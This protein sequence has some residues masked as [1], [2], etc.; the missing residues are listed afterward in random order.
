MLSKTFAIVVGTAGYLL[1]G[2]ADRDRFD[3][4]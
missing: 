3:R 4:I 1:G 2:G